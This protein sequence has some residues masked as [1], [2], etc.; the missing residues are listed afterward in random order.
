MTDKV[1]KP[2]GNLEESFQISLFDPCVIVSIE[3]SSY[4]VVIVTQEQLPLL[5]LYERHAN[6]KR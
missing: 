5:L 2:A 6:A 1:V 4:C 3:P